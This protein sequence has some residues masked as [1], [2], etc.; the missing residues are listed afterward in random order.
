MASAASSAANTSPPPFF[1]S[2][3]AL[4]L[5]FEEADVLATLVIEHLARPLTK[6][7]ELTPDQ[8]RRIYCTYTAMLALRKELAELTDVED[9]W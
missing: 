5:P 6:Y 3:S 7:R 4:A 2:S 9:I 8:P 1:A